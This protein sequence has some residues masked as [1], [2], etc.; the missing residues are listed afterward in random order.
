[1][2]ALLIPADQSLPVTPVEWST[3]QDL[4]ALVGGYI[5]TVGYPGRTDV[6]PFFNEDGKRLRL[7][8]NHRATAL[9]RGTLS[10]DD[11]V[12]GDM[13][14]VGRSGSK[15]CSLDREVEAKLAA[16]GESSNRPPIA[17]CIGCGCDDLHPCVVEA[18]Q[19]CHW[20]RLDRGAGLG[21]CS[22][23]PGS[24]ERWDAGHR[25]LDDRS[26]GIFP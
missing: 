24:V 17:V 12:V 11:S 3:L 15:E 23:C 14:I 21:V 16:R 20:L 22:A 10:P 2:R 5:E 7:P 1:M 13:V 25:D 19:A 18:P 8:P 4:Q 6:L 26:L 9:L